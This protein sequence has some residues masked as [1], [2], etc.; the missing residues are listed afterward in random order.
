[1][2]RKPQTSNLGLIGRAAARSASLFGVDDGKSY[3]ELP[4]EQ[5]TP[6]PRQPRTHFDPETLQGLAATIEQ[7]GVLQP[8]LVR[9]VAPD[10]Y[11]IIAGERRYR[12]SQLAG[13]GTI[14]AVVTS[15]EDPAVLAL[16]ENVQ[17]E[18]LDPFDMASFLERLLHQHG[19]THDQLATL[20]GKS[21]PYVT[22]LLGLLKLPGPIIA[23][24]R[25]HRHVSASLLLEIAEC[26]DPALQA[27]LWA[28]AKAGITVKALR[29]AKQQQQ[30]RD[31][32][33]ITADPLLRSS[34]RLGRVLAKAHSRGA[35]LSEAERES[36]RDLR[37][38]IDSL[39]GD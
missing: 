20:I 34:Q 17:R 35:A 21:R 4:L 27:E 39:L 8:I 14:P 38:H 7:H 22:R 3:R 37:R 9:E 24:Y 11:E 6:N 1:M 13:Q 12:A 5:V 2:S 36:L 32:A 10:A 26:D 18:D 31:P 16:L 28:Q 19:A 33:A 23:E 15:T 25:D 30:Q 29:T